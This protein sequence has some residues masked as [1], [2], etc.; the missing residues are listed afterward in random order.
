[1]KKVLS[2]LLALCLLIGAVPMFAFASDSDFVIEDGVIKEYVGPGGAIVIPDTV[3]IIRKFTQNPTI[4]EVTIPGKVSEWTIYDNE[5]HLTQNNVYAFAFCENL[6]KVTIQEGCKVLAAGMFSG[7]EKLAA[8]YLP[9]T[10]TYLGSAFPVVQESR[11]STITAQRSSGKKSKY[12]LSARG[13]WTAPLSTL[14]PT[15]PPL[16]PASP[17]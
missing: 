15:P 12:C 2:L 11:I 9:S 1:M 3:R 6:T 16:P 17:T 14:K 4:T 7:C 8:L 13:L 5:G 10:L